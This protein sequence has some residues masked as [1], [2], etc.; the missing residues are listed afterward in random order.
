MKLK[1]AGLIVVLAL[2]LA[3]A[4]Y[5]YG[6]L[7]LQYGKE[8]TPVEDG[9][10]EDGASKDGASEDGASEEKAEPEK[11]KAPDF[12]VYDGD[13]NEVRLSDFAGKPVVV[14]FWASWCPPCR[15]EMPHFEQL[16]GQV[17]EEV[18]F[19]MVNLT[20]GKRETA[21]KA[22]GFIEESG[23]TFPVYFDTEQ[24]GAYRYGISSI[25]VTVFVD[26]DGY[27][28]AGYLGGLDERTLTDE[29]GRING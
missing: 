3:G 13:G 22:R 6:K 29:I 15:N 25:P 19:L 20:D 7:S 28:S 10:P 2:V 8:K 17:K 23:F 11:S 24:D 9:A 26:R 18:V 4:Y 1:T 12:T 5:A 14:N 21:E 16:Y 27:I